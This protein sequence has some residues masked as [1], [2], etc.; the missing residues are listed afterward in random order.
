MTYNP[1]EQKE[2]A[3]AVSANDS[4]ACRTEYQQAKSLGAK[5]KALF[6]WVACEIAG[7]FMAPIESAFAALMDV[8]GK[9]MYS[10]I[11]SILD[12][13]VAQ[14][15]MTQEQKDEVKKFMG[16]AEGQGGALIGFVIY[17]VL[18]PFIAVM[19][20]PAVD[21]LE[22]RWK[23]LFRTS[24]MIPYE[25]IPAAFR[26]K[27]FEHLI[28]TDLGE[29]G[30]EEER[31]EALKLAYST[32]PMI[33][34]IR[35][36]FLR[37][38]LEPGEEITRLEQLGISTTDAEAIKRL[39][40]IVPPVADM[41]RFADFSAFDPEV[42]EKWREFYDAP[43]WVA[44]PMSKIGISNV[45]PD[46]WANRYWF[47][48][49]IQPGRYELGELHRRGIIDDDAAK[50][51]YRTMGYSAYW[52]ENLLELVKQPWTR[53]DV[54]RMW[55]MRTIDEEGL[56][57]A[58]HWLG[59]Y[60]EWLD[61]MV[62]WTKVYVGF[63]DLMAR[64]T[65]GWITLDEVKSELIALGMPEERAQEMIETKV[66]PQSEERV[67]GERDLTKA[68]IYAGVKKE[69]ISWEQGIGLL[70]GL[71]Y[72]EWEAQY[73]LA[74]R[75]G[76]AAGSPETYTEFTEWVER[77]KMVAGKEGKLPP[78]ELKGAEVAWREAKAK[79]D[80]LT[81]KRAKEDI[82]AEASEEL[83]EAEYRYR[84]LLIQYRGEET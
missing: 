32:I 19:L 47:S 75:V 37:G 52:Q 53:V 18:G 20:Q 54:R 9:E 15:R 29:Q 69:V 26:N 24:R 73:I 45:P 77:Y 31:I 66:K 11:D 59:Y 4:E 48:H 43:G 7:F 50:L 49:W 58:Y 81:A 6:K 22:H 10:R 82:I 41:V 60:D 51:A 36:L 39:F 25:L 17:M 23:S 21:M 46:E 16:E 78:P 38:M 42:I 55:D 12:D 3:S 62:L 5:I 13:Q 74:V 67:T 27:G 28:A 57:K 2:L 72:E 61:G 14:E 68:E 40:W 80:E 65:K 1:E 79:L 84:Q 35:D 56:R 8:I 83:R 70:M 63:P 33:G 64:F 34:D 76:V 30:Y 44:D 71:G